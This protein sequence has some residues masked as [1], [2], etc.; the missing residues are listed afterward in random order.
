MRLLQLIKSFL[1]WIGIHFWKKLK[2]KFPYDANRICTHCSKPE[3]FYNG[4]WYNSN[5][6]YHY[7]D[8]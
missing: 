1:C 5:R 3:F 6:Y 8:D 7:L 4:K 2:T